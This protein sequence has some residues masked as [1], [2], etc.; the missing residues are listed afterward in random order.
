MT[1]DSTSHQV[2]FRNLIQQ[3]KKN[4]RIELHQ[5]QQIVTDGHR[6]DVNRTIECMESLQ[7]ESYATAPYRK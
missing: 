6:N 2:L 4:R 7:G 5:T 3:A 1:N